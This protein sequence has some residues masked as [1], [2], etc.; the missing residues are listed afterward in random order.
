MVYPKKVI[1]L[2]LDNIINVGSYL[3]GFTII[4]IMLSVTYEIVMRYF[5]NRPTLWVLE[6]VEWCLVWMTF[7]SAPWVLREEG[8]VSID[9]LTTKLTP[10]SQVFLNVI[11]SII[12]ALIC[13]TFTWY[14]FQITWD[15]FLRGVTE[16]KVLKAPK[17][18]LMVIIPISFFLL[19]IQFL[20]RSLKFLKKWREMERRE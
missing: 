4:F 17:A 8:H 12:G 5:L 6:V 14:G 15:H 16:A 1:K 13:L 18:L 19:F 7:L 11:T 20:R 2:V 9:I 3:A 10:K